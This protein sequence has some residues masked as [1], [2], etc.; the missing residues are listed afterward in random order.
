MSDKNAGIETSVAGGER[1]V[2]HQEDDDR[3]TSRDEVFLYY[4]NKESDERKIIAT[5]DN[6]GITKTIHFRPDDFENYEM[7]QR[8]EKQEENNI[9]KHDYLSQ[10][11]E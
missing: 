3:R 7:N 11:I 8:N 9:L 10:N 6:N 2:K 5:Y 1:R 4:R